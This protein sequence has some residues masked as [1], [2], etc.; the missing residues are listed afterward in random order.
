[1]TYKKI[2]TICKNEFESESANTKYCSEKCA[3]R[4]AK[5]SY[6][7]RKMK[8]IK[9]KTYPT[10][11]MIAKII[12]KTHTLAREIAEQFKTK[13]CMCSDPNHECSNELIVHH[14]DH[15]CFN[16]HPMNL[17]WLCSKAHAELHASEKDCNVPKELK[18]YITIKNLESE[19][20]KDNW[21]ELYF[22]DEYNN[23]IQTIFE[24]HEIRDY[25]WKLQHER[26]LQ[27][28]DPEDYEAITGEKK[29][30]PTLTLI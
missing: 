14:I 20:P 2:C 24:Q 28:L 8:L 18:A 29:P 7:S 19:T 26:R 22:N 10:E 12:N 17:Q 25:N 4:G 9:S 30:T 1:M 13:V 23:A 6:R 11:K 21:D 15:D 27:Q 3:K 16:N 5:R